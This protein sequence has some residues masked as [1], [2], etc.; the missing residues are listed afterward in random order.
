MNDSVI[1][2][3]STDQPAPQ[4][5]PSGTTSQPTG[6]WDKPEYKETA[7][8]A[9]NR[10]YKFDSEDLAAEALRGH[11]NAEKLIGL[12]RAGRTIALPKENATPEEMGEFYNK[13]GR[14]ASAEDYKLPAEMKDDPVAKAF[15]QTMHEHGMTQAQFDK[16]LEFVAQQAQQIQEQQDNEFAIKSEQQVEGLKKEWGQE[17]EL[18]AETS[19]RAVRELGLDSTQAEAIEKAL[20]VDVAAKLFFQIGKNIMEPQAE[21]LTGGSSKFGMSKSEAQ[22]RISVLSSD[23]DFGKK[24]MSG[25][26][27]AKAEWDM[28]NK[29]AYG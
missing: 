20:G 23:K 3:T 8:W 21:G 17:F 22:G 5:A 4:D 10:G 16:S 2:G 7:D 29:I 27:Q 14:P 1:S 24:L 15:A 26:A 28:L 18:R 25:D 6:W 19:K 11:H 13:I 9:K 12:D